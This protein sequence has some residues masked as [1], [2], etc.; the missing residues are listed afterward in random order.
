MAEFPFDETID[1]AATIQ[2]DYNARESA[3]RFL[4]SASRKNPAAVRRVGAIID[5][6]IE[7]VFEEFPKIHQGGYHGSL[8]AIFDLALFLGRQDVLKRHLTKADAMVRGAYIEALSDPEMVSM[9]LNS[10]PDA[11]ARNIARLMEVDEGGVEN[12]CKRI[13]EMKADLIRDFDGAWAEIQQGLKQGDWILYMERAG[14][15]R[16]DEPGSNSPIQA[17]VVIRVK[18]RKASAG[19]FARI[20][21][22]LVDESGNVIPMTRVE[23]EG[24]DWQ[25]DV[26][27]KS[28]VRTTIRA[29]GPRQIGKVSE[30]QLILED[31]AGNTYKVSR[32]TSLKIGE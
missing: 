7:L 12:V 16:D 4:L 13:L 24:C 22:N 5:K 2:G 20:R 29:Q 23:E 3:M 14:M 6:W 31:A 26:P 15:S 11:A 21:V 17:G 28:S 18:N 27:A 9:F 32:K 8:K 10:E 30:L 1:A 25:G 19:S